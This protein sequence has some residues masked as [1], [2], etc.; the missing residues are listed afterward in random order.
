MYNVT[1]EMYLTEKISNYRII[2]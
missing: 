1:V 2:E